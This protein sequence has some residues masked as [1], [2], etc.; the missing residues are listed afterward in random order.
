MSHRKIVIDGVTYVRSRDAA[1][2]VNLAPDYVSRLARAQLIDGKLVEGL[3]FM[4][5]PVSV[6]SSTFDM[7]GA[8]MQN[9]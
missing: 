8:L 1:R 3:W 7:R 5:L 2:V 9:A 4:R 6:M